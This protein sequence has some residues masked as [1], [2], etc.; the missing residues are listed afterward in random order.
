MRTISIQADGGPGGNDQVMEDA[1]LHIVTHIPVGGKGFKFD[2][3]L[4]DGTIVNHRAL[5][6]WVVSFRPIDGDSAR[7][8]RYTNPCAV[9]QAIISRKHN[10]DRP[11]ELACTGMEPQS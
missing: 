2:G 4:H 1:L 3:D 9:V 7:R 8:R 6:Q 5:G 11:D 10:P